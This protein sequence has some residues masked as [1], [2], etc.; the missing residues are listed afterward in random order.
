MHGERAAR[1]RRLTWIGDLTVQQA[2]LDFIILNSADGDAVIQAFQS[3]W[4]VET[5]A[6][7]GAGNW[8]AQTVRAI[9]VQMKALPSQ[10]TRSGVWRQLTLTGDL[11]RINRAAWNGGRGD[12]LVGANASTTST[13]AMGHSTTLA[14]AAAAG[15]T[16]LEVAEPARFAVGDTVALDRAGPTRDTGAITAIAGSQYTIDTALTHAH[17]AGELLTPD[18]DTA[19]R[20]V[21]WLDKTVRHEI[22]HSVET[23]LGGVTGFT[24]GLGGWWTGTSFDT[25]AAAMGDPWATNDGSD[26]SDEDKAKIKDTIVDAVTNP[27]GQPCGSCSLPSTRPR[28]SRS[29]TCSSSSSTRTP[30]SSWARAGSRWAS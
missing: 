13:V 23:A 5:T 22:A 2:L 4:E 9:H 18:D 16:T 21:N 20:A 3:Y 14:A 7:D 17:G 10:D 6:V 29:P 28:R 25:W 11:D 1:V 15:D 27:P 19:L 24:V 30:R 12:L 26:I 8:P